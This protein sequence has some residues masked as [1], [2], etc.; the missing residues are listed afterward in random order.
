MPRSTACSFCRQNKIRCD[1]D[2]SSARLCSNCNQRGLRCIVDGSFR[3]VPAR[4]ERNPTVRGTKSSPRGLG[5]VVEQPDPEPQRIGPKQ[6]QSLRAQFGDQPNTTDSAPVVDLVSQVTEIAQLEA[7]IITR[8]DAT[9]LFSRY[10]TIQLL[11]HLS[12]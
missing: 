3:R 2:K 8:Q 11:N 9:G 12:H 7:V 4:R 10:V 5:P 6:Y 1:V